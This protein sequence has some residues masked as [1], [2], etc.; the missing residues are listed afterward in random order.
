VVDVTETN[1]ALCLNNASL[2]NVILNDTKTFIDSVSLIDV[3]ETNI[4]LCLSS[5]NFSNVILND[6]GTPIFSV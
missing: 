1:I 5:V 6:I 3:T 4:R 2:D